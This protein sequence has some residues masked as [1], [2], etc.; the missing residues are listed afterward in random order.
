M[1][2][3]KLD[4]AKSSLPSRLKSPIAMPNGPFPV[5]WLTRSRKVPSP[6]PSNTLALLEEVL[7]TARSSLPSPLISA[8]LTQA[9]PVAV[10]EVICGSKLPSPLRNYCRAAC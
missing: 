2:D 5:W 8:V 9:G 7:A 4:V 3:E 6:L 10:A 1:L